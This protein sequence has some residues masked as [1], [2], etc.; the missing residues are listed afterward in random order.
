DARTELTKLSNELANLHESHHFYESLFYFRF[1]EAHYDIARVA[2]LVME[3]ATLIRSALD[4]GEYAWLKHSAPAAQFWGSGI[5]LLDELARVFLPGGPPRND[6]PPDASSAD[7]WRRRYFR[8]AAR[9]RAA[10]IR[11]T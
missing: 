7:R 8:A 11:T 4:E 2:V 1:R 9:L 10:G 5:H 3:T 6:R